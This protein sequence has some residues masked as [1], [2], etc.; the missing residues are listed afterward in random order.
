[1][2]TGIKA[3][4]LPFIP[5]ACGFSCATTGRLN[6]KDV[7][8]GDAVPLEKMSAPKGSDSARTARRSESGIERY[9]MQN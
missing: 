1:M 6:A 9:W 8:L 7:M 4:V 3:I 2:T 5:N